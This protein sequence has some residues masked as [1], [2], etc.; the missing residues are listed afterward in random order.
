[1]GFPVSRKQEF[2][3]FLRSTG[4]S[5]PRWNF[6]RMALGF[7]DATKFDEFF[8]ADNSN[9]I[10][11]FLREA[12]QNMND[13]GAT[14]A[15]FRFRKI[16]KAD[17]EAFDFSEIE[18]RAASVDGPVDRARLVATVEND[19]RV[20]CLEINDNGKGL[21]GE[22]SRSPR[23]RET[24]G[25]YQSFS[26]GF[27]NSSKVNDNSS[28]SKGLGRSKIICASEI[29]TV[30]VYTRRLDG[31]SLGFALAL[32]NF[33]QYK[34]VDY[35]PYGQFLINRE[36]D[37][38]PSIPP[39]KDEA[40][41]AFL[42]AIGSDRDPSETGVSLLLPSIRPDFTVRS[43]VK[44]IVSH[45]A[46]TIMTGNLVIEVED[47]SEK[48][49]IDKETIFEHAANPAYT[50]GEDLSA[51]IGA[52]GMLIAGR[53]G[54]LRDL[55]DVGRLERASFDSD[56][57]E[58]LGRELEDGKPA[59]AS[60]RFFP[61]ERPAVVEG[62]IVYVAVRMP[63]LK[64]GFVLHVR[65][66]LPTFTKCKP[67]YAVMVSSIGDDVAR[68]LRDAEDATHTK[69][70]AARATEVWPSQKAHQIIPSFKD[71]GQIFLDALTKRA[72]Q[73]ESNGF[74]SLFSMPMKTG[75]QLSAGS[76]ENEGG[77]V[78]PDL[79]DPPPP[80]PEN[81]DY[82][83]VAMVPAC[84]E[85][86]AGFKLTLTESA[87][88]LDLSNDGAVILQA[89]YAVTKGTPKWDKHSPADFDFERDFE[90]RIRNGSV[91]AI[92]ANVLEI[93][94]MRPNFELVGLGDFNHLRGV[95]FQYTKQAA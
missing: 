30:A 73:S 75:G 39:M 81:P 16:H 3:E 45:H 56:L 95:V 19:G 5:A 15:R 57:V 71:G 51:R 53:E 69:W 86:K 93:T 1:M 62:S 60:A 43:F 66:R 2:D 74:V 64:E 55:G 17:L 44:D 31:V 67:G 6:E 21:D 25:G 61:R 24:P 32:L 94:K 23:A 50:D 76:G 34:G 58:I 41:V 46:Y 59:A 29:H 92:G 9:P 48:V 42:K 7:N 22:Y 90:F 63:S 72:D 65:D 70:S 12:L 77:R 87:R 4:A 49:V 13:G 79:P 91:R 11:D 52:I 18:E 78:A 80:P 83:D 85:D 27:A 84:G 8:N 37:T 35:R 68:M 33:N 38:P 88:E 82:F 89:A 54:E 26:G 20:R 40:A 14:R 36:N 28:G 10:S 47:E